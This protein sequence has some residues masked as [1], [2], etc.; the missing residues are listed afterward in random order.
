MMKSI[1][2]IFL[3]VIIEMFKEI[4]VYKKIQKQI[5]KNCNSQVFIRILLMF[6]TNLSNL[7]TN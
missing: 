3:L 5:H 6:F 2:I 7:V 1:V 4:I